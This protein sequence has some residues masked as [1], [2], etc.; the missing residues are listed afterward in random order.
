MTLED[1]TLAG[2]S[3]MDLDDAPEPESGQW[4]D[5]WEQEAL[6]ERDA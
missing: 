4:P 3:V 1:A 5:P 6:K 2:A